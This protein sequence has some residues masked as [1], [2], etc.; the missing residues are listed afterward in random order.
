MALNK[1]EKNLMKNLAKLCVLGIFA[2]V[3][4]GLLINGVASRPG[5][6]V[7]AQAQPTP[8]V[9][10]AA[11]TSNLAIVSNPANGPVN[12][13]PYV[14]PPDANVK[15]GD[16]AIPKTFTLAQ[17]SASE[18]GEVSFNHETHAG[19]MYSPDGKSPIGCVECHHT[20]QPKSALKAP[21]VTSEREVTLTMDTWKASSQK[22]A[23]CRS[24]HFQE[25]SV[26]DGKTM[27]NANG[28]DTTNEL[29]Y[30]INCNTC[31]D[32]AAKARPDLKKKTGF[33]TTNDCLICHKKN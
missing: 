27:P 9:K 8:P 15:S 12:T 3:S 30:H 13:K 5:S 1:V 6:R 29:A 4:F 25:G 28:K 24:C 26:P 19:G 33:A 32:A 14:P 23:T 31:H 2:L 7:F 16:K 21:L 18:Y 10:A 22:V 17:D 11:N 20:D